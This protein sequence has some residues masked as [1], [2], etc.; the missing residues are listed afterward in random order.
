M[1]SHAVQGS[2]SGP[3]TGGPDLLVASNRGPVS[4]SRDGDGALSASRGGGGMVSGMRSALAAADGLWVCCALGDVERETAAALG[5]G[6]LDT[7]GVDTDGLSVRMLPVDGATFDDAYNGVANQTLWFVNHLLFD[8]PTEPCFDGPWRARWAAYERY[9]AAFADALAAEAGPDA[10]VM[11]QD[12]HLFLVPRMLR[13]RRPDVAI[14]H[15]T[16]TPWAPPAYFGLLPDDVS[17]E[18]LDGMLG[19]DH[20]GFHCERWADAFRACCARL[21]GA[22]VD[23]DTVTHRGR[24]TRVG[25]H[26]LGTDAEALRE[27]A[28][29]PDV[30]QRLAALRE[31][32]GDRQII[33]RVDRTEPSKNV[34]RG[35]LSY[36]ELLRTEPQW[37]GRVTH[38]AYTYPSRQD[39]PLYRRYTEAVQELAGRINDEFAAGDWTPLMLV[40]DNDYPGSL[41]GL[42]ATDVLLTNPVRD[43][44]NLVAQEGTILADNGC[45]LVLSQ[46][47]GAMDLLGAHAH[48]VN[49][50]DVAQ[51]AAALHT[52][53][54]MPDDERRARARRMADAATAVPPAAWFADQLRAVRADH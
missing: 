19:A 32:V 25:V 23:G 2:P 48:V 29:R 15:F 11:V 47:A 35:L 13:E 10:T 17:R 50:F 31:R 24:T 1:S 6:H 14:G 38:V 34:L 28:G 4:L 54:S 49:P 27:R 37:R 33:G 42:R 44:M 52:A 39:I 36:R 26:P 41:A 20:L 43:G 51:T 18:V 12:Y 46:E 30:E 7:V 3:A 53:L 8:V 5:D 16:H 40:L 45:A 22:R 21:L 9:N